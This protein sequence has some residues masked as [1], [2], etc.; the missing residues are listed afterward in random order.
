MFLLNPEMLVSGS[1]FIGLTKQ[2]LEEGYD[3]I[4]TEK[5][6]CQ[7]P[8]KQYFSRQRDGTGHNN[9]PTMSQVLSYNRLHTVCQSAEIALNGNCTNRS[10]GG[11]S[12]INN[13]PLPKRKKKWT[14]L[15]QLYS[16]Y[17]C[18]NIQSIN[19]VLYSEVH[20]KVFLC[21]YGVRE[22][23]EAY[24]LHHSDLQVLLSKDS[25]S[26][27]YILYIVYTHVLQHYPRKFR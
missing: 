13:D 20:L 24:F 19:F 14:V 5:V 8:I 25:D 22:K 18:C 12:V 11:L 23:L 2:L 4:L 21:N 16:F 7:D 9:N 17:C 27:F 6:F 10:K 1:S 3:F 26:T 15:H